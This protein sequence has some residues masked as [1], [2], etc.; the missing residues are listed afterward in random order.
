MENIIWYLV[1]LGLALVPTGFLLSKYYFKSDIRNQGSGNMGGTNIGRI[2]GWH[3]GILVMV[4][5][6]GKA[7][8]AVYLVSSLPTFQDLGPNQLVFLRTLIGAIVILLNIFNPLFH[9][10]GG[11]GVAAG[12][13]VLLALKLTTA[14]VALGAFA[15]ALVIAGLLRGFTSKNVFIGSIAAVITTFFY[16]LIAGEP[17]SVTTMFGTLILLVIYT[18]RK[19]IK[20]HFKKNPS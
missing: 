16:S 14:I 13:G 6:A 5:D 15:V 20:E 18:H 4:V 1:S 11:K 17:G 19:N 2:F 7:I 3:W 9:F 10:K 12:A 8:L